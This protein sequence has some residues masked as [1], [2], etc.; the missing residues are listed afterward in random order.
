MDAILT[1]LGGILGIVVPMLFAFVMSQGV[2]RS[3]LDAAQKSAWRHRINLVTVL[4]T[5]AIW[6]ASLMNVVNYHPGDGWPRIALPLFIPVIIASAALLHPTLK[7]IVDG[8]PVATLV[9]AQTFR[10]AGFVFLIIPGLGHLPQ[11]FV[12]GGYGDIATGL[13]AMGTA[14]ALAGKSRVAPTL[15]VVFS[16]VG[17][18]DLLIV[19]GLL[20]YFYPIWSSAVPSSAALA[21]FSLVMVPALAAPMAL[22]LHLYAVR[23]VFVRA[24]VG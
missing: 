1:V 2:A 24:N 5:A 9:G 14:M 18:G 17:L 4:W 12:A 20:F 15:F 22:I 8:I 6:I 7:A 21:E 19:A 16:V 13:L 10:L 23:N 11:A 3:P